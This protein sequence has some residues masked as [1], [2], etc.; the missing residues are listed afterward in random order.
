MEKYK[1]IMLPVISASTFDRK[2]RSTDAKIGFFLNIFDDKVVVVS[3]IS[4][5]Q[6][7]DE[8]ATCKFLS[9]LGFLTPNSRLVTIKE[10]RELAYL[11][12]SFQ[13]LKS[14]GLIVVENYAAWNFGNDIPCGGVARVREILSIYLL[15]IAILSKLNLDPSKSLNL[16]VIN[17]QVR[18]YLFD[19]PFGPEK[20]KF[21]D[22]KLRY[23]NVIKY[24]GIALE[25][26]G[27]VMRMDLTSI[28]LELVAPYR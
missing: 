20:I 23:I 10:T 21:V 22:D 8:V 24:I 16:A 12:D 3:K 7:I 1:Y 14:Q 27:F 11:S 2:L 6:C 4:D 26:L 17:G 5:S 18:A 13:L 15:E 19:F 28:L 25:I 9:S